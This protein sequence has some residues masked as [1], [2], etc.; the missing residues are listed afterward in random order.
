MYILLA[1]FFVENG[2]NGGS[3]LNNHEFS[4]I[5]SSNGENIDKINT[6]A[7]NLDF[8]KTNSDKKFIVANFVNL[9]KQCKDYMTENL[10]YVIYEH[11]HKYLESRDPSAYEDYICPEEKL[12]N[13]DFYKSA[14]GVFCQSSLHKNILEKNIKSDNIHNLSGN[15]WNLN[16]LKMME[17]L[18]KIEK[19]E[20]YSIMYSPNPIK[21]TNMC[22][23][24]CEHKKLPYRLIPHMPYVD[25]IKELSKNRGLVFFPNVVETLNRVCVEARMMNCEV[26]TNRK[27][28]ATSE[29]WFELKGQELIEEVRSMRYRIPSQIIEPLL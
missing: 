10:D 6:F 18:S 16:I 5:L 12:I 17:K 28:G 23:K 21:N 27:V 15:L 7:T 11:D 24:Y 13:L 25:F 3:E 29:P 4:S 2:I 9:P 1:D 22:I 19:S 14:K 20:L 26:I 8:L